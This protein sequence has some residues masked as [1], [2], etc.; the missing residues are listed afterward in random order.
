M[1]FTT[2]SECTLNLEKRVSTTVGGWVRVLVRMD[3]KQGEVSNTAALLEKYNS[4]KTLS[5]EEESTST[6]SS[7]QERPPETGI[8]LEPE[9]KEE[10]EGPWAF[11]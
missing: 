5:A 4:K 10:F 8:R 2:Q 6:A 1:N 3:Y 11:L 7:V 9:I